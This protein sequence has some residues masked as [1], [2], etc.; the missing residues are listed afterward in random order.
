MLSFLKVIS[1]KKR[2]RKRN[3]KRG[4]VISFQKSQKLLRLERNNK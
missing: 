4:R 1:Q 2:I 3:E